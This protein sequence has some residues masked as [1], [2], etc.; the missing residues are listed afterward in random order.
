MHLD[1]LFSYPSLLMSSSAINISIYF[2]KSN[3]RPHSLCNNSDGCHVAMEVTWL[4]KTNPR[5]FV[6]CMTGTWRLRAAFG[7]FQVLFSFVTWMSGSV[8]NTFC[9]FH[10]VEFSLFRNTL[11]RIHL[12]AYPP[13][14]PSVD[15]WDSFSFLCFQN[16]KVFFSDITLK[17]KKRMLQVITKRATYI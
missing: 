10:I 9:Q 1:I 17:N 12:D 4:N 14:Y 5:L 8:V 11:L 16:A 7:K 15:S 6:Q 2:H 3:I 13:L